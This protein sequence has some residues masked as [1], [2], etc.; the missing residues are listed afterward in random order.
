M[1]CLCKCF[2]FR[3]VDGHGQCVSPRASIVRSPLFGNSPMLQVID[4]LKKI[5]LNDMSTITRHGNYGGMWYLFAN[6]LILFLT[7][8]LANHL[9]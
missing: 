1:Y 9:L 3:V 5:C 6:H 8:P 2:H 4:Y 7:R